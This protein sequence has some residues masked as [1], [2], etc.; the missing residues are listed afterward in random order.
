[1]LAVLAALAICLF[2]FLKRRRAKRLERHKHESDTELAKLRQG[3]MPSDAADGMFDGPALSVRIFVPQT[4]RVLC[5]PAMR[6]TYISRTMLT[7]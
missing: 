4:M 1:V 7:V 3:H 2:C 5:R 6:V